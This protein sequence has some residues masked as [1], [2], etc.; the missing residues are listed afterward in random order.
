MIYKLLQIFLC[1]VSA[2]RFGGSS[3]LLPV[4]GICLLRCLAF[5]F[6]LLLYCLNVSVH[7][8]PVLRVEDICM[9]FEGVLEML[10]QTIIFAGIVRE[11]LQRILHVNVVLYD[12]HLLLVC[13]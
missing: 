1:Y 12:V 7:V 13:I 10:L 2:T 9:L 5:L 3:V 4:V 8:R 6:P 11:Y